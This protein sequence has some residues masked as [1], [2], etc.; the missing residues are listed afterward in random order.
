MNVC[1]CTGV[2]DDDDDDDETE[3]CKMPWYRTKR[4]SEPK[5]RYHDDV[6][7]SSDRISG[8]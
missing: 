2:D 3:K 4:E 7:W 6:S 5:K 8:V 1:W